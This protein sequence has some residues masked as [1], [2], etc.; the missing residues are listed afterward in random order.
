MTNLH[1]YQPKR[2]EYRTI[3]RCRT[4]KRRRQ[5]VGAMYEWHPHTMRCCGCGDDPRDYPMRFTKI[6][7]ARARRIE[8]AKRR[9]EHAG[10][11][12]EALTKLTAD[13]KAAQDEGG[14][15]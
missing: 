7:P 12:K 5:A 2:Y 9:Y 15:E 4:C 6:T 11:L 3:V 10:T 14:A 1:L 8:D 13:I